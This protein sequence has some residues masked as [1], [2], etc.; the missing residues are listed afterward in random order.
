[1]AKSFGHARRQPLL[2]IR[3][4]S[5]AH[6]ALV[7]AELM[8]KQEGIGPGK[9]CAVLAH[10]AA[11]CKAMGLEVSVF[12]HNFFA[13]FATTVWAGRIRCL[14]KDEMHQFCRWE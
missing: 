3:M 4:R 2:A 11:F 5:I 10:A 6:G 8:L 14:A 13:A 1:M 7:I 9:W 12:L